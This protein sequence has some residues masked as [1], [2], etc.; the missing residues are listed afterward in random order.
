MF[1]AILDGLDTDLIRFRPHPEHW[2]ILEIISHL[3]DEEIEDFRTRLDLTLHSPEKIPPHI[4]P[5]KWVS[6][7]KYM[8]N[9]FS[10]KLAQFISERTKS[11]LWLESLASP[12]WN[13]KNLH[14]T[15]GIFTARKYLENWLAH[16]YLHIRQI[17]RIKY[18][19]LSQNTSMDIEYAGT[20]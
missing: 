2:T 14:P 20:W 12:N 18:Q 6:E 19:F 17:T 8:E 16:D 5:E 3:H 4:N 1:S 13:S 7:R 15:L 11:V 10:D 9:S